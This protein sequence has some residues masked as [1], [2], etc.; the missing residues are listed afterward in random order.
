M[1]RHIV[2]LIGARWVRDLT[3]ADINKVLKDTMAGKTRVPLQ[4]RKLRG[5]AIV[6]GGV[7]ERA[8]H[9]KAARNATKR[10]GICVA[11]AVLTL[12]GSYCCK[13]PTP[14]RRASP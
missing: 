11:V 14:S 12:N 6:R 1:A 10:A 13:S 3:K 2:P 5:M 7:N 4:T 8:E 9:A